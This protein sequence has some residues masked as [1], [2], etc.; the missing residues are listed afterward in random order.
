MNK[1]TKN[2]KI[3]IKRILI[4]S[5]EERNKM[6][7]ITYM[8]KTI[9]SEK[10]RKV[11]T[12]MT[13]E[14]ILYHLALKERVRLDAPTIVGLDVTSKCNLSCKH[15]FQNNRRLNNELTTEEWIGIIQELKDMK[16]Y[17]VYIMGGE[18]FIRTDLMDIIEYIKKSKMTLSINT[19]A[20]LIT[21]QM[22]DKLSE[23]LDSRFDYIQVS[24]DGA[25]E[26]INDNIR[27]KGVF[28]IILDK[29]LLLKKYGI[30]VRV[31]S[32][33]NYNNYMH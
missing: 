4:V 31:N 14:H 11:R 12:K 13:L 25:T 2:T 23:F 24:L 33:V 17:Q 29:I 22:A 1:H 19:N 15:C 8:E 10:L 30:K 16:V 28:Q 32:V 27:G 7:Y 5:C 26:E 21:E 18:P 20:T 9:N 6:D 3:L